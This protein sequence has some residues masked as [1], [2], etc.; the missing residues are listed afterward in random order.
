MADQNTPGLSSEL[1]TA[2]G[3]A[4][5]IATAILAAV[6]NPVASVIPLIESL[7]ATAINAWTAANGRPP[8]IAELQALLVNLPLDDPKA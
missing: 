7:L 6:G 4:G 8:T 5:G 3:A 1:I 2:V